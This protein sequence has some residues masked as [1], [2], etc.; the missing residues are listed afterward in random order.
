MNGCKRPK[1]ISLRWGAIGGG[2][3][4]GHAAKNMSLLRRLT[5]NLLQTSVELSGKSVHSKRPAAALNPKRLAAF[6]D[7]S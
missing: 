2:T 5:H 4:W 3:R 6:L 1:F 7:L